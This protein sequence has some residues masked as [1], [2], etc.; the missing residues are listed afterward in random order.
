MKEEEKKPASMARD[1]CHPLS[2][3]W[4]FGARIQAVCDMQTRIRNGADIPVLNVK[5]S[6]FLSLA[7][8]NYSCNSST[9]LVSC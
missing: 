1:V 4:S 9:P 8:P 5:L 6:R 3:T 7:K 2:D